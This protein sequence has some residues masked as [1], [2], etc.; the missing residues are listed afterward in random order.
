MSCT[1]AEQGA[2]APDQAAEIVPKEG[3]EGSKDGSKEGCNCCGAKEVVPD[4]IFAERGQKYCQDCWNAWDRCG[5]WKPS[6]RVST[7]PPLQGPDGLPCIHAE[8]AFFL[9][10]FLCS[11]EDVSLLERLRNELAEEGKEFTDWHGA[12][13]LAHHFDAGLCQAEPKAEHRLRALLVKRMEEAFG[14]R[15]NAVRVNY[16]RNNKDYKPMHYDRG[17][18]ENGVPQL[19]IGAS[20]GATRELTLMHVK[21]GVTMS[22]P[23]RNGDVFAFTPE[24][25]EV[26]MHGVPHVMPNSPAAKEEEDAGRLSLIIWA[27]KVTAAS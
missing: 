21:S 19:T 20:F 18:D 1:D 23:Q 25:N 10:G 14:V 16:Y 2:V 12:R 11:N 15:A 6:I 8:D 24:L 22:F 7:R 3:K 9:P 5:W 27:A 13:H 17:S 26:F 4:R